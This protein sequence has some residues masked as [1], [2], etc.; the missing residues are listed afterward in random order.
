MK[1]LTDETIPDEYV[2]DVLNRL[3][4]IKPLKGIMQQSTIRPDGS[5]AIIDIIK[6]FH[7]ERD[8]RYV[9]DSMA[10]SAVNINAS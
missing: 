5:K 2:D 10:L 1:A 6:N 3:A 9:P 4:Y 8:W 7:D